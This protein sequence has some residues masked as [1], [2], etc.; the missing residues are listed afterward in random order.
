MT[1]LNQHVVPRRR[2]N[3]GTYSRQRGSINSTT[4]TMT[5]GIF[6]IMAVTFLSFFYLSQVQNTAS[7]GSD[8]QALEERMAELRERQRSLE[9][10]GA[11]LRSIRTIE[12]NIPNLNL[13]AAE[14]VSYLTQPGDRLSARV[15]P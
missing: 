15:A 14:K 8:I 5:L 9:L 1:P 2:V 10:E 3:A 4:V 11:E 12:K 6:V 13:V 7:Q